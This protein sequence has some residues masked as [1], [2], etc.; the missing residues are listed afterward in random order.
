[1]TRDD[2]I[3]YIRTLAEEGRRTPLLSGP[4][5]VAAALIFGGASLAQWAIQTGLWAVDPWAQLWVWIGAGVVF[6]AALAVILGRM[7][8]KP[9][10]NS[11]ANTAVGAAWSGI[12]ALI[13]AVWL[14]LVAMGVRTGD[15]G[16]M[17]IMPSLVFAAYG[18]GWTVAA[19]MS[20]LKWINAVA[21]ASYAGA[22]LLGVFVGQ[23]AGYLVFVGLLVGVVFVPGLV[24]MRREP[25]ETA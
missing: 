6:G 13:F 10:Y 20:G 7:K 5:L 12:G 16:A 9:G 18:A 19:A 11:V 3:A 25:A 14:G 2:D 4:V 23:A 1:M 17:Q 21:L 24:L 15:W 8:R 22:V